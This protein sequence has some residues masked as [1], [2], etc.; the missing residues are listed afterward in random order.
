M[1]TAAGDAGAPQ[2]QPASTRRVPE[3]APEEPADAARASTTRDATATAHDARRVDDAA[4]PAT[5]PPFE[6]VEEKRANGD[7]AP[8]DGPP[9]PDFAAP[10]PLERSPAPRHE[11][12]RAP[13]E[14]KDATPSDAD[15]RAPGNGHSEDGDAAV[16]TDDGA[17]PEA[18]EDK[19]KAAPNAR[20]GAHKAPGVDGEAIHKAAPEAEGQAEESRD[21]EAAKQESEAPGEQEEEE[22]AEREDEEADKDKDEDKE[23]HGKYTSLTPNCPDS[24]R[25]LVPVYL[26]ARVCV[27]VRVR[28]RV[29]VHVSGAWGRARCICERMC[30]SLFVRVCVCTFVCLCIFILTRISAPFFSNAMIIGGASQVRP[31]RAP[32]GGA[33]LCRRNYLPSSRAAERRPVLCFPPS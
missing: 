3:P 5:G 9:L 23:E 24:P 19:H 22:G 31:Q 12:P 6:A 33:A 14:P 13:P 25:P 26:C 28:V 27:C 11:E 10:P 30:R 17:V 7:M 4:A 8:A 16:T 32:P 29:R 15:A 2:Q 18:P 21:R 20:E 1:H